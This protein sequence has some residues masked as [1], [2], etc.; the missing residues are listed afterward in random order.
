VSHA[1]RAREALR[2][3]FEGDHSR[4]ADYYA[5]H[6][7]DHVNRMEFRGIESIPVSTALPR[8]L[9][10][11]LSVKFDR[12]VAEGDLVTTY[13]TLRG[14]HRGRGVRF[15]GVSTHRFEGEKIVECWDVAD[16]IETFRQLGLLRSTLMLLTNWRAVLDL[17]R[18][19][20]VG[21][22]DPRQA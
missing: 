11:D 10:P 15:T 16:S 18:A 20:K 6:F 5:P 7:V 21:P 2:E 17:R 4:L 19:E 8:R 12:Q 13:W 22:A 1:E 14:T 3:T 9:C